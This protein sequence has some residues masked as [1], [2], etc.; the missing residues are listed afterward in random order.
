[1][2]KKEA[3]EQVLEFVSTT[4]DTKKVD[5]RPN[6]SLLYDLEVYGEDVSDFIKRFAQRFE[7][8]FENI[9]LTRFWIGDE[10]FSFI[11]PMIRLFRKEK[12][13]NK[14]TLTISDLV[15]AVVNKFLK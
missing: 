2:D 14:P 1:M 8:P 12:T 4:L 11:S 5:L 9:D 15:E 7:I 6:T 3:L 13:E 10:P